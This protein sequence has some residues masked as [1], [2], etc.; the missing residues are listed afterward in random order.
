MTGSLAGPSDVALMFLAFARVKYRDLKALDAISPFVLRHI[1]NFSTTELVL[2]MNGH[3]KL[4]YERI[5]NMHLLLSAVCNRWDEW[6]GRHIALAAN[7]VAY[8]YI[9]Q[10]RFWKQVAMSLPK[11][12]WSMNPLELS[13]LVSAMARVDRRDPRSLIIIARMCRRCAKRHLFSQE[14][15]AT[16]MNAFA[17]LDFNHPKLAKVFED[18]AVVKLD[19]ALELGSEYRKSG[20]LRGADVFDVQALVLVFQTLVCL[21]GTSDEVALKLLTLLSWSKDEVSNYQRRVLKTTSKVLRQRHPGVIKELNREEREALHIFEN[22]TA[23]VNPFQSRWVGEVRGVL[24][25]MDIIVELKPLVDDQVLD[26]WLPSSKAVVCTVGPYSY[27]AASTH[28]TAYSKLHQRILEMEGYTCLTVPYFEWTELKTEEDKMV[29]LWSLGRKAAA[30]DKS[31]RSLSEDSSPAFVDE[32][33]QSDL[34]DIGEA[35]L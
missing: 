18:A 10:P 12:V 8:F 31:D 11:I 20:S 19:R 15:L 33:L 23:K 17:K 22:T 2:L 35:R 26:I 28:R 24:R 4:E 3:K 34:S 14:T 1:D 7:A 29:Y 5:D 13:N 21:V 30:K 6:T 9:Y 16:T 27:Y 32:E 25:K